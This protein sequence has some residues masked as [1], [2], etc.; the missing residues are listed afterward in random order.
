LDKRN[1]QRLLKIL[2]VTG[3]IV[4]IAVSFF[5]TYYFRFYLNLIP[6]KLGIPDI[7]YYLY[8][9]PFIILFYLLSFNYSGLYIEIERK[10][11]FDIFFKIL[12][13]SI[14][15][16]VL[17]LSFTFF[18]RE[19]TY[20]RILMLIF[21]FISF[22]V[23]F[24]WRIGFRNLY[25]VLHKHEIII[26]RIIIVGATEL[27]KM[28]IERIQRNTAAGYK[29][30]GFLDNKVKKSFHNVPYLGK[31]E[32]LNKIIK[33]YDVDEIF[34]GI[35]DFDRN[36]LTEFVLT[37]E[38]VQFKIASD[39]LGLIIRNV[40]YDELFE[41]PVF[42]VK[43]LPLDKMRNR[44][45]KRTMDIVLSII[46]LFLIFP[47]FVL[48]GIIIKITSKGPVFYKQERIS[49][50]GKNFQML[51]FRTMRI[52]AEKETGPVW[53]KQDDKR[54]TF[55]GRILRKT[56]MDELPQLINVLKGDMSIVGPR[57]ERPFFVN[58]FKQTIPRYVERHKVRAGITGWAQ[59]NGLRGNTSLEERVKYDL[60][61][62]QNW[63]LWFD[64][65]II[66]RTILE[67]FHH[68]HA[69]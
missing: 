17:L 34:I 59:V 55:I 23:L 9:L 32:N 65:K 40:E 16:I 13:S 47:L 28:L 8:L 44:F 62:I 25:H 18:I 35:P 3:D 39:I 57:P 31:I 4:F 45:I 43:D 51:K 36:K 10:S 63:S 56:S 20:S 5:I 1:L 26:Q 6:V 41:I 58:K 60:Y 48:I 38:N 42:S 37:N 69:Y 12:I 33:K 27:S 2:L 67:I 19:I 64:I 30:I 29:I 24:L 66:I 68:K 54:V 50:G 53:A 52:D 21:W 46:I 11:V 14:I 49:R 7:R 15:A 61:Y 22:I